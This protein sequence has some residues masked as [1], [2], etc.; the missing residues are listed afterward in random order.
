MTR[1]LFLNNFIIL[2]LCLNQVY[3]NCYINHV[4]FEMNGNLTLNILIDGTDNNCERS[5]ALGRTQ[6]ASIAWIIQRINYLNYLNG[7]VF[8]LR[9]YDTCSETEKRLNTILEMYLNNSKTCVDNQFRI[10][11]YNFCGYGVENIMLS[12]ALFERHYQNHLGYD[13]TFI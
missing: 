5:L 7:L 11:K 2:L 3:S 4:N 9:I 13:F 12:Q 1:L 10:R 6:I 8:G